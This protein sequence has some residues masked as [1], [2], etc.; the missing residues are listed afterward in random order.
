M[1]VIYVKN[2]VAVICLYVNIIIDIRYSTF[3]YQQIIPDSTKCCTIV[4]LFRDEFWKLD[5]LNLMSSYLYLF[6]GH[7]DA[8]SSL[9]LHE[10]ELSGL[11]GRRC[12]LVSGDSLFSVSVIEKPVLWNGIVETP[13]CFTSTILLLASREIEGSILSAATKGISLY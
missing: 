13:I 11:L 9:I 6:S 7:V 10:K 4:G 12:E 8:G 2:N 3:T 5:T 1:R